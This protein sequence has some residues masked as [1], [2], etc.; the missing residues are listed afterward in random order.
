VSFPEASSRRTPI[1]KTGN[2][3]YLSR[4]AYDPFPDLRKGS[5]MLIRGLTNAVLIEAATVLIVAAFCM[6]LNSF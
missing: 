3:G 1:L 6:F 2:R 4:T 5:K